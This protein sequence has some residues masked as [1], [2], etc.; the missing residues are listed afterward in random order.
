MTLSVQLLQIPPTETV[1][2]RE[3][4]L[5]GASF[6]IGRDFASD[7]CLPD[8]SEVISQTHLI[9]SRVPSGKYTVTDTSVVGVAMNGRPLSRKE[10]HP[11]KDGDIVSF[12][13]YKLLF[14]I[15]GK[16]DEDVPVTCSS[17]MKFHVETD[18]SDDAP[19][20]P[21]QEVEALQAESDMGFSADEMDLDPDLLFDPFAEGPQLREPLQP[22]PPAQT[23]AAGRAFSDPVEIMEVPQ[24]Q[25]AT[26]LQNAHLRAALYREQVSTAM[27]N[28]LE[29]FLDELDPAV[30]QD[31][32][33]SYIPRLVSRQKRYWKIH[34]RQFAKKK[35]S[36]EFRRT[37]LA[38]FAEEMRKL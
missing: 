2:K 3:F 9:I 33:D 26:A 36:G 16:I 8:L 38:L 17:E 35:A 37:F 23:S 12:A 4:Y 34:A 14:G 15:V 32:Y 7:I 22:E 13:G 24:Y 28:A 10:P 5:T 27:E 11:L 30:L 29:R 6:T 21:D 31:D 18:M 1:T 19:L 25:T 20:L